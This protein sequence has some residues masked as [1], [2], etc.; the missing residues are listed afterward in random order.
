MTIQ[1]LSE[2]TDLL[3]NWDSVTE[4][5]IFTHIC[6]LWNYGQVWDLQNLD[7]SQEFLHKSCDVNLANMVQEDLLGIDT[8]LKCG[9]L[10]FYYTKK[11]IIS[12]T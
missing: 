10:H 5:D 6:F 7:W 12:S 1:P 3:S 8:T 4:K 2:T 9:P 11:R